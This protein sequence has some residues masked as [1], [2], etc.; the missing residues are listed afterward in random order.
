MD[1]PNRDGTAHLVRETHLVHA[2]SAGE[3]ALKACLM[4]YRHA[5]LGL[6]TVRTPGGDVHRVD[7]RQL[8][9]AGIVNLHGVCRL[10]QDRCC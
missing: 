7:L 6:L 3:A 1:N 2:N 5:P 10:N 8:A 9:A 4:L